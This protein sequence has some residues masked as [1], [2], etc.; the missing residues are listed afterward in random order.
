ML[1]FLL[2]ALLLYA[3]FF[4][5]PALQTL[6]DSFTHWEGLTLEKQWA[7]FANYREVF[8]DER[9]LRVLKNTFAYMLI[10]GAMLFPTALAGAWA[11]HQPIRGKKVMQFIIMAPVV[12]SVVVAGLLWKFLYNPNFGPINGVLE[13][14]GL[15]QWSR[16][17]LGDPATALT[18][19]TITVVWHGIG[20]WV[21]MLLAALERIPVELKDAA[22]IDGAGDWHVFR[23]V[24]LPLMWEVLRV[25]IIYWVIGSLNAF[26]FMLI[27]TGGGPL[28]STDV[29]MYYLYRVAFQDHRWGYA[30]ALGMVML[31]VTMGATLLA[32]R[33]LRRETVEY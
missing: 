16:P 14:L 33:V 22:R 26:T 9:L 17:W 18:A 8:S 4:V 32:N 31:L 24:E 30:T 23:Y 19:V 1:P 2:P 15:E 21:V 28:G 11:L 7:G 10:G 29:V 5:Y 20:T 27:M 25:L 13:A 3:L 6:P 12:L